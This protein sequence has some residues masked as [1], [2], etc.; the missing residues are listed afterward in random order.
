MKQLKQ[1]ISEKLHINKYKEKK[2]DRVN[3]VT[4]KEFIQWYSGEDE[5]NKVTTDLIE[6]IG[7]DYLADYLNF[8]LNKLVKLFNDNLNNKFKFYQINL[9]NAITITWEIDDKELFVDSVT[10]YGEDLNNY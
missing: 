7:W 2:Y 9:G 5:I 6:D 10:Y 4:L 3:E 1:F 8:K